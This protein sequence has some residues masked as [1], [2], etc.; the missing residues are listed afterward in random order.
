MTASPELAVAPGSKSASPKVLP[1]IAG[2]VIVWSAFPPI[3]R[4]PVAVTGDESL[5]PDARTVKVVVPAGVAAVVVSVRV[6][7]FADDDT[8]TGLG[9]KLAVTPAGRAEVTLKLT[10]SAVPDPFVVNEIR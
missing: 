10:E 5:E 2:K 6:D 1:E 4:V 9:E 7:V 8:E 3:V